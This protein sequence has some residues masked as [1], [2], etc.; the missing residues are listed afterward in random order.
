M[1]FTEDLDAFFVDFTDEVIWDNAEYKGIL[2]EPDQILAD[3]V[4]LSTEYQLTV[5]TTDFASVVFDKDLVINSEAYT[6]RNMR[7]IDDGSLS[8]I[9]LSK[10]S[11]E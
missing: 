6:V 3:G 11:E 5:K 10:T 1:P 7:K 4:V 8:I 9:S 2:E